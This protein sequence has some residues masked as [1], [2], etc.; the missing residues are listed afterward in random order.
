MG[1]ELLNHLLDATVEWTAIEPYTDISIL[2]ETLPTVEHL[3]EDVQ[4]AEKKRKL[5]LIDSRSSK[6]DGISQHSAK[7]LLKCISAIEDKTFNA[8]EVHYSMRD[9]MAS[10]LGLET[11]VPKPVPQHLLSVS[12]IIPKGSTI[13]MLPLTSSSDVQI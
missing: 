10:P 5:K 1:L 11:C 3:V 13:L 2:F 7:N 4:H 6:P 12:G 8:Q 9:M